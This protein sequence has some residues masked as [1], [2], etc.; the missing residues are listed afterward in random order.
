MADGDPKNNSRL[1]YKM[2]SITIFV[3]EMLRYVVNELHNS[4]VEIK[5]LGHQLSFNI[6]INFFVGSKIHSV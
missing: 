2:F 3:D 4:L 5:G 6:T 1:Y